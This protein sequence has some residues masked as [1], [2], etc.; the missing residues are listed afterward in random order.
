MQRS[1]LRLKDRICTLFFCHSHCHIHS[2]SAL[3]NVYPVALEST[4][5]LTLLISLW[6]WL[7]LWQRN[8]VQCPSLRLRRFKIWT[9]TVF[10]TYYILP[11]THTSL[12]IYTVLDWISSYTYG[13]LRDASNISQ[14]FGDSNRS[15]DL[16]VT[17]AASMWLLRSSEVKI[18]HKFNKALTFYIFL[19]FQCSRWVSSTPFDIPF[20]LSAQF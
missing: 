6:L 15:R 2:H 14:L 12:D 10:E 20:H 7:W 17:I 16:L 8:K 18:D 11:I 19:N 3:S 1:A 4:R 13:D 9:K 5:R